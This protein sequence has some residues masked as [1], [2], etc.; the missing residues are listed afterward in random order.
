V[1]WPLLDNYN[2]P[3]TY[4]TEDG[5]LWYGHLIADWEGRQY[6][7]GGV[8]PTEENRGVVWARG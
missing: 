1:S 7:S 2:A 6:A 5:R 3:I 8:Y 4:V